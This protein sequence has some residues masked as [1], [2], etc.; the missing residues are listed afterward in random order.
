M[1]ATTT[2]RSPAP[3]AAT[4]APPS[5]RIVIEHERCDQCRH[6]AYVVTVHGA[7]RAPSYLSWCGHHHGANLA[8]GIIEPGQVIIDV[9]ERLHAKERGVH[10]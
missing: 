8:A 6:R 4:T 2:T 5:P 10:A 7:P 1:T 9:R 3:I